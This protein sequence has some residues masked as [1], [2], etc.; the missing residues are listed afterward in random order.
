[1]TCSTL[2][3]SSTIAN[4][5]FNKTNHPYILTQ[6]S[7][8]H[9]M[10]Q[11]HSQVVSLESF[12]SDVLQQDG[13][14]PSTLQA[15]KRLRCVSLPRGWTCTSIR[16]SDAS[17][18]A[19]WVCLPSLHGGGFGS[20]SSPLAQRSS[21]QTHTLTSQQHCD[22]LILTISH[23]LKNE[24]AEEKETWQTFLQNVGN[25]LREKV[26]PAPPLFL[27]VNG[28]PFHTSV[29]GYNLSQSVVLWSTKFQQTLKCHLR[30]EVAWV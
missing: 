21:Q 7:S 27:G 14:Q 17:Y 22:S 3:K 25:S 4:E 24:E 19:Q 20:L 18:G 28:H 6:K 15:W 2:I 12:S 13:T 23:I 29:S 30:L 10:T 16:Q 1:M 9:S 8:N 5:Q 26:V 11:L